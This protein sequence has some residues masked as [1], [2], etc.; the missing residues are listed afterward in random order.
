MSITEEETIHTPLT[1]TFQR[2]KTLARE[3]GLLYVMDVEALEKLAALNQLQQQA[4]KLDE[5]APE[6]LA[7]RNPF[8]RLYS[9]LHEVNKYFIYRDYPSGGLWRL[10]TFLSKRGGHR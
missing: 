7:L 10:G 2:L 5:Y 6:Q 4:D 1:E 8:N 3:T 9:W